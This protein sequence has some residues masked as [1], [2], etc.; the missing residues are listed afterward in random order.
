MLD[1]GSKIEYLHRGSWR[2]GKVHAIRK[3]DEDGA[4]KVIGYLVDT[5]KTH[6]EDEIVTEKGKKNIHISQPV[7]IDVDPDNIRSAS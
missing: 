1:L 6:L 3:V 5:G 7:Q 4:A 2:K